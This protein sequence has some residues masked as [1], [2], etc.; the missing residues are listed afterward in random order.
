MIQDMKRKLEIVCMMILTILLFIKVDN[1]YATDEKRINYFK[2]DLDNGKYIEKYYYSN[3][4]GESGTLPEGIEIDDELSRVVLKDCKL[5]EE[6]YLNIGGYDEVI[7]EG[8]NNIYA[9]DTGNAVVKGDGI[10]NCSSLSGG[11][12]VISGQLQINIEIPDNQ[13][14]GLEGE[15]NIVINSGTINIK[16]KDEMKIFNL[17][18]GVFAYGNIEMNG[19]ALNIDCSNVSDINGRIFAID[20]WGEYISIKNAA[21][22]IRLP[23]T[24]MTSSCIEPGSASTKGECKLIIENSNCEMYAVNGHVLNCGWSPEVLL[25]DNLYYYAGIDSA[26]YGVSKDEVYLKNFSYPYT[27]QNYVKISTSDLGI[28]KAKYTVSVNYEY[29]DGVDKND[30]WGTCIELKNSDGSILDVSQK[31]ITDYDGKK[32]D[33][34]YYMPENANYTVIKN[35]SKKYVIKKIVVN[36]QELKDAESFKVTGD[37]DIIATI[38][39]KSQEEAEPESDK[40]EVEPESKKDTQKVDKKENAKNV[41]LDNNEGNKPITV[42]NMEKESSVALTL[43]AN[44]ETNTNHQSIATDASVKTGDSVKYEVLLLLMLSATIAVILTKNRKEV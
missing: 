23:Y 33:L 44:K 32:I 18:R 28:A 4:S 22:N 21:L 34:K 6:T 1:A 36:N 20:S 26:Q 40:K 17:Y 27:V 10:L 3:Q 39:M 30:L 37:I 25:D 13:T 7:L 41:V 19:G 5:E 43:D 31:S 38:G 24:N 14:S 35:D 12:L 2:K 29:E 15:R 9:L 8:N 42:D 16:M 11:E